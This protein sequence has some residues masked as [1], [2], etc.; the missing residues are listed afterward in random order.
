V[1]WVSEL[2]R[3]EIRTLVA[4]DVPASV[5]GMVR[6]HAN[7][8]PW[9]TLSDRSEAGLNHY[10]EPDARELSAALAAH[11]GVP[12]SMLL[13]GRGSDEVIDLLVRAYCR[14][15]EDAVLICPPTF[16]TYQAA[17]QVQGAAVQAIPLQR[18]QP[19]RPDFELDAD[20]IRAC[21][22]QSAAPRVKLVFVCS[23]N[24][25]TGNRLDSAR[26]LSLVRSLE[27]RAL[28]VVDEAYVEFSA[29]PSLSAQLAA[30]PGLVVLRTLS[31]AHGLAGL[32]C[33]A[34]LAQPEVIELLRKVNP[35]YT[36]PQLTIEAVQRALQ[37]DALAQMQRH[38]RTLLSER[39][40]MAQALGSS[41]RVRRVWPSDTNFLLVEFD[42]AGAALAR[43]HAAGFLLRDLRGVAGLGQAVRVSLGTPE[44]NDRLVASLA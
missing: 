20:A 16:V 21:C 8:L 9:R 10:P 43:A 35:P 44:Q 4:P 28:V 30:H 39:A 32:R 23:P 18:Y 40:R 26:I 42:D 13:P 38:V 2:A 24:N 5:P 27:G 25:P 6:L 34:L 12:A 11:Y 15:G 37:P 31:K 19:P 3:P 17:A 36:T 29:E 41:Q 22:L 1:S 14:A 33:G 7:E